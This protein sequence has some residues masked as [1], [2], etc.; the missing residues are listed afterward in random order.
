MAFLFP[1]ST[2]SADSKFDHHE[3]FQTK[4]G[5]KKE[6]KKERK[7]SIYTCKIFFSICLS[8]L[9]PL[10][11]PFS[12]PVFAGINLK[13]HTAILRNGS[14]PLVNSRFCQFCRKLVLL[15]RKFALKCYHFFCELMRV[16]LTLQTASS[17]VLMQQSLSLPG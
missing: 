10:E 5:S 9:E 1:T 3:G 6:R 2:Y 11:H 13:L 12:S 15:K 16:N 8:A 4:Q 7:R 14:F 17:N